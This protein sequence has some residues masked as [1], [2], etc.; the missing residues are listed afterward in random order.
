MDGAE[1]VGRWG[2]GTGVTD[3][4]EIGSGAQHRSRLNLSRLNSKQFYL[5]FGGESGG[6]SETFGGI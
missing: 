1:R 2:G 3:A 6:G 5:G 4:I